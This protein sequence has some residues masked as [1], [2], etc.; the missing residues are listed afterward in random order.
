MAGMFRKI[1][2]DGRLRRTMAA[3]L[4]ICIVVQM[5]FGS[6]GAVRTY[7]GDTIYK[8]ITVSEKEIIKGVK[9]AAG[10]DHEYVP[11]IDRKKL[12]YANEELKDDAIDKITPFLMGTSIIE[13]KKA[14]DNCSVIVAVS[15][16]ELPA[17]GS[18][19]EYAAENV[20]FIGFNGNKDSD[21][22]FTLQ[23]V[24]AND[25]VIR[26][27]TI[28]TY[29]QDGAAAT[30]PE[31]SGSEATPSE[32]GTEP[33]SPS[34]AT[35]STATGSEIQGYGFAEA[36][37][38]EELGEDELTD[39]VQNGDISTP[40]EAASPGSPDDPKDAAG[41]RMTVPAGGFCVAFAE[42]GTNAHGKIAQVQA[43][44]AD[45]EEKVMS[46]A[47]GTFHIAA[48]YSVVDEKLPEYA[49]FTVRFKIEDDKGNDY[50]N[51]KGPESEPS[52]RPVSSLNSEKQREWKAIHE[53][54]LE[55]SEYADAAQCND[56]Q[57][58]TAETNTY[59]YSAGAGLAVFG[60]RNGGT[61]ITDLPI[62]FTFDNY[63][64]PIG[65][66]ITAT[67]GILNREE[68]KEA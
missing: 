10:K 58:I 4:G 6:L 66:A 9:R 40:G 1:K 47:I 57:M 36:G 12:P 55:S 23:I 11:N 28:I 26:S 24:D 18:E 44:L 16:E 45:G 51:V 64:T 19:A 27:M 22:V 37:A 38:R 49:Y 63:I 8:V 17:S 29:K 25:I 68:L 67:P 46:G 43:F 50:G 61:A 31:A 65:S 62:F 32:D 13:Q 5:V 3:W 15:G 42:S 56:W 2:E 39:L 53:L 7:A 35:T 34:A 54:L 14:G 41:P 21:C 60:I 59:F 33:A 30:P 20:I 48:D 52:A